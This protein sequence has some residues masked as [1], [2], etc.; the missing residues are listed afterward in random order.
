M[1]DGAAAAEVF[2]VAGTSVV[3]LDA[4]HPGVA[5]DGP[6]A[7]ALARRMSGGSRER[8]PRRRAAARLARARERGRLL[9]RVAGEANRSRFFQ[10]QGDEKNLAFVK[11]LKPRV[12]LSEA[13]LADAV[14]RAV[15]GVRVARRL[16]P[17]R[18]A[19]PRRTSPLGRAAEAERAIREA[20]VA[21]AVAEAPKRHEAQSEAHSDF[22]ALLETV[23]WTPRFG[24]WTSSSRRRRRRRT[25]TGTETG[26]G[27]D[28]DVHAGATSSA[29]NLDAR[30][31]VLG[32]CVLAEIDE[33]VAAYAP[34]AYTP[35]A[36]DAPVRPPLGGVRGD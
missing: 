13:R 12:E 3:G 9:E 2:S 6:S 15:P 36:P 14:A 18:G 21:P 11:G 31:C 27:G 19:A 23:A 17:S 16:E 10:T 28:D 5:A 8:E 24:R 30:V 1:P 26:T 4:L 20:R 32:G 22:A 33:R 25:E 35:G 34:G 29:A 7:A